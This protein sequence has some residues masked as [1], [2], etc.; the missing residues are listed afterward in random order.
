MSKGTKISSIIYSMRIKKI[1][2]H[3][4]KRFE[5]LTIDLGNCPKRIIALVGPN[6]CGKSSVLDSMLYTS[7]RYGHTVG[8]KGLKDY[9]YHSLHQDRAYGNDGNSVEID[10]TSGS[11]DQVRS[12]RIKS[13]TAG[14]MFS[15]R[16]PYRY[17]SHLKIKETKASQDISLNNYGATATSD[18]DDK[19]EQ[20]YRR[21]SAKY[22]NDMER[23]DWKPSEAKTKIIGDLNKSIKNCLDLE[24]ANLGNIDDDKGTLFFKKTDTN[25]VFEFDVLSSGEKEVVDIL[26]D[27]YLR[28]D[29][30]NDTVFLIDEPELHINTAIQRK[31]LL[32]INCLIGDNCQIWIATHSIGFLRALQEELKEECDIIRFRSDMELSSKAYTLCPVKKRRSEWSE[33]FQTALDDLTG[34]VSPKRIIYCEGYDKPGAGGREKG[35]DAK[36]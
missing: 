28:H 22:K 27:L 7:N 13:G 6:G 16:S 34:L 9:H 26:L 29:A 23:F 14:T 12:A 4:Y 31:L 24:I 10:F 2:L 30:Y 8:N 20:S 3:G 19:M 1:H 11:Y 33:I 35:L 32:E 36:V 21:L 15:F 25:E 18:L 17:N 5:D